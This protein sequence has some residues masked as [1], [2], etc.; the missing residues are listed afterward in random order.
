M[1]KKWPWYCHQCGV[2]L[3]G[4]DKQKESFPIIC[5]SCQA[6]NFRGFDWMELF[7]A[8][9]LDYLPQDL[10]EQ[11]DPKWNE[12][13]GEVELQIIKEYLEWVLSTDITST[14]KTILPEAAG[15]LRQFLVALAKDD[16]SRANSLD[17][18]WYGMAFC[19]SDWDLVTIA[20]PLLGFM[21]N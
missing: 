19:S 20:I 21:W 16:M 5:P 12:T 3:V 14:S 7:E 2:K 9:G 6:L 1:A 15:I 8:F 13:D 4:T 10:D 17:T 18:I 11:G